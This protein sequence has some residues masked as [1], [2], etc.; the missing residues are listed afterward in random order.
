MS[1]RP[2]PITVTQK[3]RI[4]S[5]SVV[6]KPGRA[7]QAGEGSGIRFSRRLLPELGL[8]HTGTEAE[9][10]NESIYANEVA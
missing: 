9:K 1:T 6:G 8:A 5:C 4:I 10:S 7:G 2:I 3:T